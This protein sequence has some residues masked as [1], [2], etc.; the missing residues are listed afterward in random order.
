LIWSQGKSSGRR[1]AETALQIEK[2]LDIPAELW[3]N[4]EAMYHLGKARARS[5]G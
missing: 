2:A 3:L 4:L 1:S 5:T